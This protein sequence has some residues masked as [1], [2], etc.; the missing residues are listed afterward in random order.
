MT[1]N[2]IVCGMF[3]NES[4]VLREWLEHYLYHGADH[5]F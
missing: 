4:H 2:L 1:Y 3:K 5:F